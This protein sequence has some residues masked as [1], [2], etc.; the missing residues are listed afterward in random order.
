MDVTLIRSIPLLGVLQALGFSEW[1]QRKQEWYG[2]CPIHKGKNKT[3]F[4]FTSGL[5]NCFSC[6]AKGRG[7]IDLV[8]AVKNCNYT[9]AVTYLETL[10]I[11]KQTPASSQPVE[12]GLN[13]AFEGSYEKFY[14]PCE[15]LEKRIPNEKI[16]EL[17]GVGFY[18]NPSRKSMYSGKVMLPIRNREGVKVG[19]LARNIEGGEPKYIFPKGFHKSLELYGQYELLQQFQAVKSVYLVESPFCVMKF[20][21]LGL[22]AVSPFGWSVSQEQ[23]KLL[24]SL[25]KGVVYLPDRNK[26]S[27]AETVLSR[28]G[29]RLWLRCPPLPEG[30]DDPEYLSLE[31]I[32]AL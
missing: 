12:K 8:K 22:P 21:S 26:A 27:E 9:E 25:A 20:A 32:H 4:S 15:W 28:L 14:K 7:A 6:N 2:A 30:I 10:S 23:V 31:Q 24:C 11:P 1:K 29:I 5:F 13:R 19:Y 16:R 18:D 17:Y 3:A